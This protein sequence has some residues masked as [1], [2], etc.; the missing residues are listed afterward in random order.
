MDNY[1]GA[2]C[3]SCGF[4]ADCPGCVR[5]CGSPFGGRC[6]AA[7]RIKAFGTEEYGEFKKKL[8]EE[9]NSVLASN[10]IPAASGLTEL[11]GSYINLEYT[12]PGGGKIKL[13]SDKD[14]YL[15]TQIVPEGSDVCYGV[16]AGETFI[17]VCSYGAGGKDPELVEYR[18]R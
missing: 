2:D 7:E 5:T 15:G 9:I 17:L 6:V 8:T 1:C 12:A 14:V 11:A 4:R 18:K 13:L 10:G 3:G 16:A